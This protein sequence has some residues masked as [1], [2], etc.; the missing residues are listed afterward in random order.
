M[1]HFVVALAAEAR[2]LITALGLQRDDAHDAFPVYHGEDPT[3][4]PISLVVTGMGA[5]LAAAGTAH[6]FHL[7]GGRDHGVWINVGIAGHPTREVGEAVL[8]LRVLDAPSDKVFY[9]PRIGPRRLPGEQIKTVPK[10]DTSYPEGWVVEMEASGF[11]ATALRY[12]TAELVQV[13][14]VISDNRRHPVERLDAAM[15]SELIT[16]HVETVKQI[17]ADLL[18]HGQ[19]RAARH[20]EPV[21]FADLTAEGRWSVTDR[22]ALRRLLER[23]AMIAPELDLPDEVHRL[24]RGSDVNRVLRAWLDDLPVQLGVDR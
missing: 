10:V 8:G 16:P 9:P 2:P 7:A 24:W 6:L 4:G 3:L 5:A 18:P 11:L 1:L 15:V 12:T 23:R 17:A 13:I 20:A 19:A 21:G 14:K 22:R